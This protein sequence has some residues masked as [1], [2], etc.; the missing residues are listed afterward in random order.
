VITEV[1]IRIE[2]RPSEVVAGFCQTVALPSW[3]WI[4]VTGLLVWV[5]SIWRPRCRLPGGRLV[6]LEQDETVTG[7]ET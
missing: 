3:S 4:F 5:S 7:C 1:G 6:V 2:W